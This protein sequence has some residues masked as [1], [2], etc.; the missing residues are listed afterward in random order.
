MIAYI[1]FILQFLN[2][3]LDAIVINKQGVS[4]FERN[5]ILNYS[6]RYCHR[7]HIE[8]INQ[9]QTSLWDRIFD[10]WQIDIGLNHGT[11]EK[12]RD[13]GRPKYVSSLL[14]DKKSQFESKTYNNSSI[15]QSPFQGGLGNEKFDI[16]VETLWEVIKEYMDKDKS[17]N[18]PPDRRNM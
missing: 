5:K 12:F 15:E 14:W 8:S 13:I 17:K 18:N 6:L 4:I 16:L 1:N 11:V 10:K 7:D 2:N 3:Y 9:S